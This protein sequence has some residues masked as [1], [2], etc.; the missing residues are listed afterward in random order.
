MWT[1]IL[2]TTTNQARL[3]LRRYTLA[4]C[5]AQPNGMN[6]HNARV[7]I[8]DAPI[9]VSEGGEW[10]VDMPEPPHDDPRWPRQCVCGYQFL[11]SEPWQ[12][13]H[14][15]LYQRPDTGGLLTLRDTEPG[16]M[17]HAEWLLDCGWVG[18]D[19]RSLVVRLPDGGEWAID[20]PSS[21]DGHWTRIGEA[22][23]ITAHPSIASR[24]YHG[25][26]TNGVLSD[27]IEGR[28]YPEWDA[29]RT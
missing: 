19:G 14:D 6:T 24:K 25:W 16:M 17:W 23:L 29:R 1:C 12:L 3:A 13:A 21:T 26:L 28:T 4:T 27:D 18:S 7:P 15:R 20:A 11:D 10:H 22:P 2:L 8:G 5:A 9:V